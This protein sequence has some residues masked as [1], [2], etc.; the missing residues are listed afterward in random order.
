[1]LM[2]TEKNMIY[3]MV[4]CL[5]FG[6]TVAAFVYVSRADTMCPTYFEGDLPLCYTAVGGVSAGLAGLAWPFM[7]SNM[8][9]YT[10]LA[11]TLTG[12]HVFALQMTI[13]S[14]V[15]L[16]KAFRHIQALMSV[17]L[18]VAE[19]F[20]EETAYSIQLM[21][22]SLFKE[23][24]VR[25]MNQGI[26]EVSATFGVVQR[27]QDSFRDAIEK[28]FKWLESKGISC[29]QAVRKPGRTC[30]ASM[31]MWRGCWIGY[32]N[33]TPTIL[34]EDYGFNDTDLIVFQTCADA[35]RSIFYGLYCGAIG[36]IGE[37]LC[38]IFSQENIT[39]Y[40][41]DL[42]DRLARWVSDIIRM[43]IGILFS[44]SQTNYVEDELTSAW[45][46]FKAALNVGQ[47][48]LTFVFEFTHKYAL[49]Y[50]GAVIFVLWPLGYLLYYN[51]GP[52]IFD[53]IYIP[54]EEEERE[55]LLQTDDTDDSLRYLP[56][57][58][59]ETAKLKMAPAWMV[60]PEEISKLIG[61]LIFTLDFVVILAVLLIDFYY[62]KF[63]DMVYF[64]TINLFNRYQGTVFDF[65]QE[66][67]V[68]GMRWIGQM[69]VEKLDNLQQAAGLGRMVACSQRAPP[70][71][72][73]YEVFV[74][75]LFVR[76]FYI[77]VQLKWCWMP[78]MMCGRYNRPRHKQR[79]RCRKAKTL[80]RRDGYEAPSAFPWL[81]SF[82]KTFCG[83]L[84]V[85]RYTPGWIKA[86]GK[87]VKLAAGT[88]G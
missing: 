71:D 36:T 22:R 5:A 62:T 65:V 39:A 54:E 37:F 46:P 8:R 64:A 42:R 3:A 2:F 50:A 40:L 61:S 78:S 82:F 51:R 74:A 86:V 20:M 76:L 48:V 18:E 73:G 63:V 27:A 9:A 29:E 87:F 31:L 68:R 45:A 35:K 32:S 67:N 16:T 15:E 81:T 44:M 10:S 52:L 83:C 59:N 70:I 19:C 14:Y 72:Y 60:S 38:G 26:T 13:V 49:K 34:K 7:S 66:E 53:N 11:S 79:M 75:A 58:D 4:I 33:L 55:L 85:R 84:D 56:L 6:M 1:M 88:S 41:L 25:K 12:S 77:F 30:N 69:L 47:S 23:S 24:H 28:M 21:R 43:R 57:Q 17:P 80:F